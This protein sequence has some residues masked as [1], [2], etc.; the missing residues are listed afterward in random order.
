MLTRGL[1]GDAS[2]ELTMAAQDDASPWQ[3]QSPATDI[4]S[5]DVP[6]LGRGFFSQLGIV[7]RKPARGDAPPTLSKSCSDKIALK[8]C[9]SLL[10]SVTSL[11]V[12]PRDVYISSLILPQS[13]YSETAC[14]RALSVD[15][16]MAPLRDLEWG[17]GY[18][19]APFDIQTTIKEFSHSK[20]GHD[21]GE[22]AVASN[23]AVAWSQHGLT[24][25]LIGGK[26]Q[27]RKQGDVR[28]ASL[29]S[30][31]KMWGLAL[32][33]IRSL[34]MTSAPLY[35]VLGSASYEELKDAELLA[36]RRKAKTE[37]RKLALKGWTRN[38][39]D[40]DFDLSN[41]KGPRREA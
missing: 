22:R 23:L 5:Q 34:G 4:T 9:T 6:L 40:S 38:L 8:Q 11:L 30:R 17:G 12:S 7:R 1:G 41:M 13:Q 21:S 2:M 24:E 19:F 31:R 26:L 16:R 20:R 18:S 35:D 27:G 37:A 14:R 36:A 3:S 39:G 32:D 15:G 28:G 25:A 29:V 33:I 10:N